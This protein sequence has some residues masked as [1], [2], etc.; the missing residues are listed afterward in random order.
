MN[1]A[2]SWG[3]LQ[4]RPQRSAAVASA[5]SEAEIEHFLPM[6]ESCRVV[7]GRRVRSRHPLLGSYIP[8]AV[9][10]GWEAL[11]GLRDVVGWLLNESGHPAQVLS[12]EIAFLRAMCDGD[13]F[14][15]TPSESRRF[16]YGQK[17]SPKSGP[18]AFHVGRFDNKTRNG[19]SALFMLFGREQRV[20]FKDGELAA[21]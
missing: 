7:R 16:S 6:I 21:A 1:V 18:L 13:L 10:Q 12:R 19:E 11:I 8:V 3:I 5:L 4:A 17:V 20:V 14:R 9:R 15:M 2:H